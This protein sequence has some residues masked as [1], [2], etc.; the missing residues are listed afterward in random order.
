MARTGV[1]RPRCQFRL[2]ISHSCRPKI[3]QFEHA[4]ER[5][6]EEKNWSALPEASRALPLA[7]GD[8]TRGAADDRGEAA[9][10]GCQRRRRRAPAR[11]P[12]PRDEDEGMDAL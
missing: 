6:A 4:V 2:K 10:A 9:S 3:A 5:R 1:R 7:R 8:R 11:R 12:E